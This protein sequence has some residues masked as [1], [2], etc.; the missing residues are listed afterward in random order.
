MDNLFNIDL[1]SKREKLTSLAYE[2]FEKI[3][4]VPAEVRGDDKLRTGIMVLVKRANS[5]N[6]M[7]IKIHQPS[8]AAQ[9]FVVEQAVR[10]AMLR[11]PTSQNSE[12]EDSNK[13]AGS[14]TVTPEVGVHYQVSTS[15]L[16]SSEDVAISVR[17]MA[18]LLDWRVLDVLSNIHSKDGALPEFFTNQ[19]HYA[20]HYLNPIIGLW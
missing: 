5:R 14:I 11:Q 13:Y 12:D 16:Q 9:F 10:S 1:E 19:D 15:G 17:I 4:E 8:D 6:P 7:M 2:L 20:K 18:E 3:Q